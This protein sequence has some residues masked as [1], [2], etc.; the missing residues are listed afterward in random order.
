MS[1]VFTYVSIE[2]QFTIEKVIQ[3]RRRMERK[4]LLREEGKILCKYVYVQEL[5]GLECVGV[6]G[7][8]VKKNAV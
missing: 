3:K 4:E 1:F 7:N 2:M 6:R 8:T 5:K